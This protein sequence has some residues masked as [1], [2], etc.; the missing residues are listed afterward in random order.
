MT[1]WDPVHY[2]QFA[3]ERLQPGLDL[4]G[5]IDAS[6]P[7]RV[8]D[9]GCGTG[10]LT[11]SLGERWPEVEVVGLDQSAEMLERAAPG[12]RYETGD[13]DNWRPDR[14]VDVIFAN[15]S[16]MWI[17]DHQRLFPRLAT[18]LAAGGV[19]AVQMPLS[20]D[21]PSHRIM[22]EVAA[23]YGVETLPA[24]TLEPSDYYQVLKGSVARTE[25][26]ETTY[27]HR[28][29]GDNPVFA[30]VSATGMKRFLNRIDPGNH[31]DYRDEC[32]RQ[33][34]V[35]YPPDKGGL[36]TFPFRRL[37]VLAQAGA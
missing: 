29:E 31:A 11:A 5:R 18:Q 9:L 35:A 4:I 26:W 16:L 7:A 37:F 6:Q 19:L 12:P 23:G 1:S 28:L 34:R 32:A 14:P 13:I 10:Q 24:P 21:Q 3:L 30:W 20:W 2:E 27:L 33:I 15:A 36:T 25:I 17:P 22:R 8:V